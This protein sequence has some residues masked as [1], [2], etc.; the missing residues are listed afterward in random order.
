L[1]Q[2]LDY[3]LYIDRDFAI[4]ALKIAQYIYAAAAALFIHPI[5]FFLI[6]KKTALLSR[7]LKVCYALN[8]VQLAAH[9]VWGLLLYQMHPLLP[10]PALYC[11]GFACG[12]WLSAGV[13]LAIEASF[14]VHSIIVII[15][16]LLFMSQRVLPATSKLKLGT[17]G[18]YLFLLLLYSFLLLNVVGCAVFAKESPDRERILKSTSDLAWL[19]NLHGTIVVFGELRNIGQFQYQ[20]F[21]IFASIIVLLPIRLSLV[22]IAI[23]AL[24]TQKVALQKLSDRTQQMQER[25][26]SVLVRQTGMLSIFY[27][28]PQMVIFI[29]IYLP[30]D[31]LPQFVTAGVRLLCMPLYTLNSLIQFIILLMTN[32]RFIRD[33]RG[34]RK[35]SSRIEVTRLAHT[36]TAQ[37]TTVSP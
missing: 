12:R 9:D 36:T 35:R 5:A 1:S 28:Y 20:V 3:G 22:S 30:P 18:T 26:V 33:L 24:R 25:L 21:M 29:F 14:T 2:S 19:S 23:R 15:S 6:L 16:T 34:F 10:Y 7:E 27:I 17:I 13:C 4:S 11:S 32:E 37:F 8:Q 31:L